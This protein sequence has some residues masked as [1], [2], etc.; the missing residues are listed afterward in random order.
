MV[1]AG[2]FSGKFLAARSAPSVVL[3]RFPCA[4]KDQKLTIA[5]I[6]TIHTEETA[7]ER[8]FREPPRTLLRLVIA[9]DADAAEGN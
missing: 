9:I 6:A 4:Y 3:W 5:G 8:H 7:N 2:L 1:S